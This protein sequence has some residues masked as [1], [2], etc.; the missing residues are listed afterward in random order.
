MRSQYL[1]DTAKTWEESLEQTCIIRTIPTEGSEL[2]NLEMLAVA[3]IAASKI[4]VSK[5]CVLGLI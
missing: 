2:M 4:A 1:S 5:V 3:S